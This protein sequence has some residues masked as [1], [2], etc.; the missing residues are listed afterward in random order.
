MKIDLVSCIIPCRNKS[1]SLRYL[2]TSKQVN[3]KPHLIP[4]S[5]EGQRTNVFLGAVKLTSISFPVS[6]AAVNPPGP[7]QHPAVH[8]LG[9]T[10]DTLLSLQHQT[11][12]SCKHPTEQVHWTPCRDSPGTGQRRKSYLARKDHLGQGC[13]GMNGLTIPS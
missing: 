12:I 3:R 7:V 6:C 13:Y 4:V 1:N 10:V 11:L 2:L 9:G 5:T 8:G